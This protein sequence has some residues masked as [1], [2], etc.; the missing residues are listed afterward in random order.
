MLISMN[1]IG[2]VVVLPEDMTVNEKELFAEVSQ[3]G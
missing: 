1:T 2:R 3:Y